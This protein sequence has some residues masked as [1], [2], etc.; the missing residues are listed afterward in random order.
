MANEK[1]GHTSDDRIK[2][3]DEAKQF[4]AESLKALL[5]ATKTS[6]RQLIKI[7]Q[8][9]VDEDMTSDKMRAVVQGKR[10]AFNTTQEMLLAIG[11]LASRVEAGEGLDKK[12]QFTGGSAEG[13]AQ[14]KY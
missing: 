13:R 14:K 4:V 3:A 1:R 6:S 10:D 8:E 11:D 7:I 2:I 5:E 12:K 9:D